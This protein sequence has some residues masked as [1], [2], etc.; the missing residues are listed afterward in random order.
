MHDKFFSEEAKAKNFMSLVSFQP[1]SDTADAVSAATACIEGKVSKSLKSFLKKQLKKNGASGEALAVADKTLAGNIKDKMSCSVVHDSKTHEL[2]R[3]IRCYMDELLEAGGSD[4][5]T[6]ADISAMQLGL[7]HSLSRYKL[8][9][10]ADKVDTMVI[11][12]I[13][14]LDELDKEI[15]T[16]AMR[17]KEWYGWHFPG[18]YS[19]I[20]SVVWSGASI[21]L[22][23]AF[24]EYINQ[25]PL[26]MF[27]FSPC[28]LFLSLSR[29]ASDR[30]R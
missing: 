5:V 14:L 29:N 10:S 11:Q 19:Q 1:F 20:F 12:A 8:K 6:G 27:T 25:L 7:S 18:E 13:G 17:A 22:M 4:S 26:T 3:G 21:L 9:F 30:Q 15:N 28:L 24:Q 23:S 2:F 16:Y